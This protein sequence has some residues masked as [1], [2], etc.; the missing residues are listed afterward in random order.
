MPLKTQAAELAIFGHPPAFAEPLHVGRPNLPDRARFF[1]SVNQIFDRNLLTNDGPEVRALEER[2]R[3]LSGTG[4]AIAVSNATIGLQLLAQA[5]DLRGRVLMPAFTFVAT[6]H[7]FKWLGLEPVFCDINP[8]T[9]NLDPAQ[10]AKHL[11]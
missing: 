3:H 11:Q 7:A 8:A 10:A 9:H 5:L 6:A 2:F 4:H 1:E